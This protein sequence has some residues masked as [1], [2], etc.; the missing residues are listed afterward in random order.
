[1]SDIHAIPITGAAVTRRSRRVPIIWLVPV[2]AV[3]IGAWLA[4][5]TYSKRGPEIIV[6]FNSAEG[7]QAGQSQLKYK[8]I[9]FGTVKSLD[10]TSDHSRV[11]VRIE[12]TSK[13]TSLLTDQTVFWVAKPRLFAGSVS[14]LETL[15]SGSYVAMMPAAVGGRAQ[16][17][18]VGH[19]DPPILSVDAPGREFLLQASR[20]GSI[21]LGSPVFFRDLEVG[22]VL[23]WDIAK[24]ARSVTIRAFVRSPYD[25]EVHDETRFWNASGVSL[26][27]GGTGVELQIESL[28]ALLLGG[29]A[30]ETPEATD[31]A[32]AA[33]DHTFPLY[34]D[35]ESANDAS[36]QRKIPLMGYFSGSVRGLGRDSQVTI[37]GLVVGRVLDVRLIFDR[38]KDAVLAPV[39]FEIDPERFLGVGQK[40]FATPAEGV[41]AMVAQGWRASLQS[42]SLLTGQQEIALELVPDAAPAEVTTEGAF[43]VIPVVQSGGIATLANSASDLMKAVMQIPFKQIGGNL[44]DILKAVN[45]VANGPQMAQALTDLASMMGKANGFVGQLDSGAGPAMKELPKITASLEKTLTGINVLAL[46]LNNGYGSDTKFN[47]DLERLLVQVNDAV[48]SM[49]S[50]ADLLSRHPE[51]LIK[52]RTGEGTE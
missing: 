39:R 3:A 51:A 16:R 48:R 7:L 23:G 27:L 9:V 21:S 37:H 2:L 19:E 5:D 13:A 14:G 18:F 22:Q 42:A 17:E 47:H 38:E 8:D 30:F 29:I 10:L 32:I 33:K 36:Y 34:A 44:E 25:Q 40:A 15:V 46:S 35:R 26:K 52:G 1:M 4:W 45:T 50:L 24:G 49:R 11:L 20:I 28:R 43:L 6:S 41:T 12:T 31:S